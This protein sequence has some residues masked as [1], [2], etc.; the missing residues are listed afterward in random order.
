MK[1]FF[2]LL[3]V[4][5]LFFETYAEENPKLKD[6]EAQFEAKNYQQAVLL[7]TELIDSKTIDDCSYIFFKRGFSYYYLANY[8]AS[9][10]DFEIALKVSPA[11]KDYNFIRGATYWM[12]GRI[13]SKLGKPSKAV[14]LL[15]KSKEYMQSSSLYSTLGYNEIK[16]KKYNDALEHLNSA[17]AADEKNAYAFNNRALV[18]LK[19]NQ[20]DKAREDVEQSKVLDNKNPYAYKHSALIYIQLKEYDKACTE[21]QKAKDLGYADYL[22]GHEADRNE[23]DDLI[24]KYCR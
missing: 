6:A 21:L 18:Y 15:L 10:A 14:K 20:M 5:M 4:C 11:N 16:L 17:I 9:K 12:Y 19:L 13:Y 1:Y 3:S 22:G 7:Y 24:K 8:K 23:V 2:I